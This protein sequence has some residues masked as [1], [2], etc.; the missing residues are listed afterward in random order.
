[1]F[2]GLGNFGGFGGGFTPISTPNPGDVHVT[3]GGDIISGIGGILGGI[4]GAIASGKGPL[5]QTIAGPNPAG[6]NGVPSGCS[7]LNPASWFGDCLQ[8]AIILLLG[9]I[10]IIGGIYLLKPNAIIAPVRAAGRAV[11]EGAA[12]A[13]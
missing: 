11:G 2:P 7:L 8:R 4:G 5:G 13:A 10:L 9:I 1:M 3:Q 12:A 6:G